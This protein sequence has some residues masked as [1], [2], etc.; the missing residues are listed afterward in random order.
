MKYGDKF[1]DNL[2]KCPCYK[3]NTTE[4]SKVFIPNVK[5]DTRRCIQSHSKMH[6]IKNFPGEIAPRPLFFGVLHKL[7]T[8]TQ[9]LTIAGV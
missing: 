5:H 8:Y 6:C 4:F 2:K 7:G 1:Y 3:I 9:G